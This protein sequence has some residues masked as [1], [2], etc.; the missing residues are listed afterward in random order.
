MPSSNVAL[1]AGSAHPALCAA[2]ARELEARVTPC[3]VERFPDGELHVEVEEGVRGVDVY[4]VQPTSPPAD[5]HLLEL[6]FLA[7]ACRRS[8]AASAGRR[9]CAGR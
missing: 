2:I 4:V 1:L 6:V 9:R 3:L 7:D 5:E 8:G